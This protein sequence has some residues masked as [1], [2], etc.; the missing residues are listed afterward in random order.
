[1]ADY[2]DQ[3]ISA[4]HFD[5]NAVQEPNLNESNP[6]LGYE[7]G[8]GS[9]K[10]MVG[11]Y[12][13]S[14]RKN[15]LYAMLGYQPIQVGDFKAG[16]FGGGATG[17]DLPVQPVAGGLL[18]YD[19]KYFGANLTLVPNVPSQHVYGFAGLQLKYPFK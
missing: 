5:R 6:G 16:V 8:V 9:L 15:S 18:S 2:L 19:G 7:H 13:N 3:N 4:Y 12:K 1:M 14:D 11:G 17:Y 10:Y